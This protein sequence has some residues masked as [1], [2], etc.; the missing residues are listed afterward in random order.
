MGKYVSGE[1]EKVAPGKGYPALPQNGE[2]CAGVR[3][4]WSWDGKMFNN[5]IIPFGKL[6]NLAMDSSVG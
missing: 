3:R 2:K 6:I 4:G 5:V 1:A